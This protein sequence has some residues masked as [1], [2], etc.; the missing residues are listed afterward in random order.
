[1]SIISYLPNGK[2]AACHSRTMRGGLVLEQANFDQSG[3]AQKATQG[4]G[5]PASGVPAGHA[6]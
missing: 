2:P 1:M 4:P 5:S 6:S 3:Q